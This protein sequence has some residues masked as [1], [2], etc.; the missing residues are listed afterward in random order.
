[1][2]TSEKQNGLCGFAWG[3]GRGRAQVWGSHCACIWVPASLLDQHEL[4]QYV[5]S[6]VSL[7]KHLDSVLGFP[8]WGG[9]RRYGFFVIVHFYCSFYITIC[10]PRPSPTFTYHP[11]PR[12][13]HTMVCVHEFF[14]GFY[15]LSF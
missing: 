13:H 9:S 7:P 4:V 8:R 11:H 15:I 10:P 3:P 1:M 6:P 5:R 12:N 2:K 14:I